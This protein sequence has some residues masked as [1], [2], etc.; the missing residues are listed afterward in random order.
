MLFRD[1]L[2]PGHHGGFQS[3]GQNGKDVQTISCGFGSDHGDKIAMTFA[4]GDLID[5]KHREWFE[6]GPID[7]GRDPAV[8]DAEQGI[9]ADILCLV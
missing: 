9:I 7:C 2:E 3:I 5:A 8:E 6:R 1:G 4:Q